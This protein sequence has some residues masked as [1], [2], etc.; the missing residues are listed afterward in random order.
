MYSMLFVEDKS[1]SSL[2]PTA[3]IMPL[4][5]QFPSVDQKLAYRPIRGNE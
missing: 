4:K 1:I 3:N 2:F 5:K